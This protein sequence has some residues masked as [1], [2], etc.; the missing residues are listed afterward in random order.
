MA[1][2]TQTIRNG[3]GVVGGGPASLWNAHNWAAFKWGEGTLDIGQIIVHGPVSSSLSPTTTVGKTI[4]HLISESLSLSASLGLTFI[5]GLSNTLSVSGDM[6][7]EELYDA[8]GYRYMFPDRTAE[9]EERDFTTWTEGAASATT[10][11][12]A[13]AVS[14][15][16]SDA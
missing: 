13:T 11:T 16:W 12:T 6:A 2:F 15:T 5:K 3:V 14:T 10:W 9:G 1:D 4:V 7:S 8:S